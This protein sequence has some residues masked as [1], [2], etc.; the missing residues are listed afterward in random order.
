MT[1]GP[2][3]KLNILIQLHELWVRL[4]AETNGGHILFGDPEYGW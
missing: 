2:L 1:P 4:Q 3:L